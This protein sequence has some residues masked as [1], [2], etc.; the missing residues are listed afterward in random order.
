LLYVGV[1]AAAVGLGT[2]GV[3]RFKRGKESRRT[4]AE[5]IMSSIGD[6]VKTIEEKGRGTRL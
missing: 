2:Y 6:G 1:P 5:K 4:G 3:Y